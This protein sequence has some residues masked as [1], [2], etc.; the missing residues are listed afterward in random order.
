[1]FDPSLSSTIAPGAMEL[2]FFGS[3]GACCSARRAVEMPSPMAVDSC[4]WM[5]LMAVSTVL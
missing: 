4:N 1:M 2:G 3:C 5:L